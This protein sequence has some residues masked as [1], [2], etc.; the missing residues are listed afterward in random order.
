M[1]DNGRRGARG[2]EILYDSTLSGHGY[3]RCYLRNKGKVESPECLHLQGVTDTEDL[4]LRQLARTPKMPSLEVGPLDPVPL[5][6]S[7]LCEV[8]T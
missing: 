7:M 5:V 6:E 3:S 2:G 1:F 8:D 4:C